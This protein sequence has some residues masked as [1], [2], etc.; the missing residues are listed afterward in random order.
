VDGRLRRGQGGCVGDTRTAD[1]R[2]QA[3]QQFARREGLRQ[4]VVRAKLKANNSVRF[5]PKA[6]EHYHWDVRFHSQPPQEFKAVKLRHHHV[7]NDR[8]IMMLKGLA[9]AL[10]AGVGQGHRVAHR[11]KV[12]LDQAAKLGVVVNQ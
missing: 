6:G 8:V 1:H 4:V 9:Q 5:F 7:Q 11:F 12:G 10:G 2:A 3:G